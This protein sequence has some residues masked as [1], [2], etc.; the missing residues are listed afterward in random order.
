MKVSECLDHLRWVGGY[1]ERN[2]ANSLNNSII[3]SEERGTELSSRLYWHPKALDND[4][5]NNDE[6]TN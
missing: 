4:G 1:T 6:H 5:E 3:H 2:N